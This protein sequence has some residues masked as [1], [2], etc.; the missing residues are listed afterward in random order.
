MEERS[1][2]E[3]ALESEQRHAEDAKTMIGG[4][5]AVSADL[6][7]ERTRRREIKYA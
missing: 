4:I 3:E 7:T 2:S 6:P 5:P 1:G